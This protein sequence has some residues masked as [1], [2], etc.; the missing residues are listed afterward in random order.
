ML[1]SVSWKTMNFQ[2]KWIKKILNIAFYN[3]NID[4]SLLSDIV[5]TFISNFVSC[6]NE[7][8][9]YIFAVCAIILIHFWIKIFKFIFIQFFRNEYRRLYLVRKYKYKEI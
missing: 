3:N 5:S 1:F 6:T 7:K 2:E 9:L 4:H 8:L